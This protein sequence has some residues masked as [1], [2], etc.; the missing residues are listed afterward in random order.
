MGVL[1][2]DGPDE[3]KRQIIKFLK[4]RRQSSFTKEIAQ[5]LG[6]ALPTVSKYLQILHAEGKVEKDEGKRPYIHWNL[7]GNGH[8]Q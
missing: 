4:N 8:R 5:S 7:K 1:M 6:L 2:S 3:I